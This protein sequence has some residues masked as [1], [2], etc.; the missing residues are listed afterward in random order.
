MRI[1]KLTLR[2]KIVLGA[3]VLIIGANI[4]VFVIMLKSSED[5]LRADL[6]QRQETSIQVL[7][8]T[9]QA[10]FPD[11]QYMDNTGQRLDR[12]IWA[13]VP[14]Q[15]DQYLVDK[16]ATITTDT[17]TIFRWD[18]DKGDFLRVS[19]NILG[20]NG[21][22][23]IGT[24]LGIENPVHTAVLAG[25]VFKGGAHILGKPYLLLYQ[26]LFNPSGDVT[27][28]LAAGVES[29][30][31]AQARYD[32]AMQASLVT[33]VILVISSFLALVVVKV[34]FRPLG[35]LS[36][37][38]RELAAGHLDAQVAG[39]DRSDEIGSIASSVEEFRQKLLSA[40][41]AEAETEE[42]RQHQVFVLETLG[43]SLEKLAQKNMDAG[44]SGNGINAFPEEYENLRQRFDKMV[45]GLTRALVT[46]RGS[47]EQTT[48][49]SGELAGA[50]Q[51]LSTKVAEQAAALEQSAAAVQMMSDSSQDIAKRAEDANSMS[52]HS[53]ERASQGADLLK[54]A[55]DAMGDIVQSSQAI[56]DII[57]VIDDIAF[58]TNILALNAGVE[59]QRSG[60]HGKG[61]SVV[62][63][64][65]GTLAQRVATSAQD[66]KAL[67]KQSR[68]Q[69]DKGSDLIN[70]TSGAIYDA[71]EQ[72][73]RVDQS[74]SEI[75][76]AVGNQSSGLS[77][78][79]SGVSSLDQA[80]QRSAIIAK[81]LT[82]AGA[83]L[84][85]EAELL[86]STIA[87]FSL[88]VSGAT[89]VIQT[90]AHLDITS[91]TKAA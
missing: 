29:T 35:Q 90:E 71:L 65:V 44:L 16:V 27:G 24:Y 42:R 64:E 8:S 4:G 47:A 89:P 79:S 87:E 21:K 41:A 26:P 6:L 80:T 72:T 67:V 75:A 10:A 63:L 50:A 83:S 60:T 5:M 53:R 84:T 14:T 62:A 82:D 22:P 19:T 9:V 28:I 34:L 31:L 51:G 23:A 68:V 46:V 49:A 59:A 86:L 33:A 88:P 12:A 7:G 38:I 37:D 61:F 54:Q 32:L 69:V 17:A 77:E 1:S 78:L 74:L 18:P 11:L 91:I 76:L 56:T 30:E 52:R 25:E 2:T 15:I 73:D 57:N 20:S 40:R 13:E 81:E 58:Q 70:R 39:S 85:A 45:D 48:S 66:I 43:H 55:V 3:I 36:S